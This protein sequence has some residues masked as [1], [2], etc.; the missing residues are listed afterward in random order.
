MEKGFHVLDD[1]PAYA[2]GSLDANEARLVAEHLAGCLLCRAELEAY[3]GIADQ[4]PL[5]VPEAKPSAGIKPQLF[6]RIQSLSVK[7]RTQSSGQGVPSRPLGVPIGALVGLL[8]ILVLAVS[9]ILLWQKVNHP[10]F[11]A[12]PLGMRAIPL[13]NAGAAP[14]ASG[15]V[16][17][18]A[19]GLNG[20]VVVDQLP[21]LDAEHEYQ[22]W[23]ERD[24]ESISGAVFSVDE[25]G[26]RG[27]RIA[28]TES[29][30]LY[31]GI[32]VTVEP[33]GGSKNPTGE[34]VLSGSLF[35]P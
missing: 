10:S 22:V 11:L 6:E 4:L 20:V 7:R 30:L 2:L 16:V 17:I 8:L 23:L 12:G 24:G 14:D 28:G 18:S 1:L 13:Q 9:N 3:Q 27:V 32:N 34:Q 19:D 35:N 15:F 25:Y 33:A 26:Y 5:A 21:P 29:L 31:S